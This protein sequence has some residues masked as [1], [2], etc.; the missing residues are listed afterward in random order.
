MVVGLTGGIGSGKSIVTRM[1]EILGYAT[2]NSDTVARDTYFD[3]EIKTQVIKLLGA[4][5]YLSERSIN[6]TY[7]G[8]LIFDDSITLKKLNAIIHP[9]VGRKFDVFKAENSHKIIIKETALLFEANLQHQVDKIIVVVS[10]DHER[11]K[12]VMER[13]GLS[14]D[15]V[16]KKMKNQLPQTDKASKADFVINNNEEEFLITQ[17]LKI[18]KELHVA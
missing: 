15:E 5:A 2:F 1:F 4:S 7:I 8:S 11:T 14:Q 13:D 9:A 6:K 10:N 18:H 3:P 12:R 17:V 16:L